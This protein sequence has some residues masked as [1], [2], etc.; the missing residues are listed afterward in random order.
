VTSLLVVD[1]KHVHSIT[2]AE[3]SPGETYDVVWWEAV[4][5]PRALLY[6]CLAPSA[7]PYATNGDGRPKLSRPLPFDPQKDDDETIL[8]WCIG[9]KVVWWNS[10]ARDMDDA[11]L[12]PDGRDPETGKL[13]NRQTKIHASKTGRRILTF[14][15]VNGGFRSVALDTILAVR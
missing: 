11:K 8:A 2:C 13:F 10:I 6:P 14:C 9:R 3:F 1:G 12:Y 15:A 4:E 5:D 7:A